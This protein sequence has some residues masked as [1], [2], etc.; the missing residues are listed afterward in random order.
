M[1]TLFK[2]KLKVTLEGIH[3][4]AVDTFKSAGYTNLVSPRPF[5]RRSRLRLSRMH[6]VGVRFTHIQ[7]VLEAAEKLMAI[8]CFFERIVDL[9]NVS[10]HSDLQ[11]SPLK[12]SKCCRARHR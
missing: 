8:G 7:D 9:N 3:Q 1:A 4:S 5:H 11:R 6:M 10:R 2:D 12:H